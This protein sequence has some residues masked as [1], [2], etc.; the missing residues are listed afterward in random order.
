MT[1]VANP[2]F[3]L[4]PVFARVTSHGQPVHFQFEDFPMPH[5]HVPGTRVTI[6][7]TF[8][9]PTQN[10]RIKQLADEL[11]QL[12]NRSAL[13]LHSTCAVLDADMA[14]HGLETRLRARLFD[15]LASDALALM[16]LFDHVH[17]RL[18]M[19]VPVDTP[20]QLQASVYIQ[21]QDMHTPQAE[22]SV[23][24]PPVAAGQR[25]ANAVATAQTLASV[26]EGNAERAGLT[27][28]AVASMAHLLH[29]ELRAL[30]TL[31]REAEMRASEVAG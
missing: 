20:A 2:V 8:F 31:L 12:Q 23:A 21:L 17:D 4:S 9:S 13:H 25:L 19:F 10:A 26:G 22:G 15:P 27:F 7:D 24:L 1:A 6:A 16:R 30:Q 5:D 18:L 29:D 11:R 14:G 3:A 28:D